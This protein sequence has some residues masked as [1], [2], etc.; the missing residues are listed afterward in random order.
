MHEKWFDSAHHKWMKEAL[1]EAKKAFKKNE[2]PIGAVVVHQEK[3]VGRGHNKT[4]SLPDATAHA[5]MIALRQ[6]TRKL[7]RWRLSGCTLYTTVEPCVMCTGATV[8]S[9]LDR[10]VFAVSDLKGGACGSLYN[11]AQDTRLNHQIEI[12]SGILKE[13]ASNLLKQFFKQ[14][15][16]KR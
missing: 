7:K 8:L 4:E 11:I 1:K 2:V 15:R 10:L 16:R 3:I 14:L 13:E 5:E 12:V 6:A 9:R